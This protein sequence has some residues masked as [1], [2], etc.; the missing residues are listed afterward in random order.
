VSFPGKLRHVSRENRIWKP[1]LTSA[2]AGIRP[3]IGSDI[4]DVLFPSPSFS[5]RHSD[6]RPHPIRHSRRPTPPAEATPLPSILTDA[7]FVLPT[8]F[9]QAGPR[10]A[11]R[12]SRAVR[13]ATAAHAKPMRGHCPL[14]PVPRTKR[15]SMDNPATQKTAEAAVAALPGALRNMATTGGN[16]P[17]CASLPAK[18]RMHGIFSTACP[19]GRSIRAAAIPSPSWVSDSMWCSQCRCEVTADA[20]AQ[21]GAFDV[22]AVLCAACRSPLSASAT[23]TGGPLS[24]AATSNAECGMWNA[25]LSERHVGP[26]SEFRIPNSELDPP[27]DVCDFELA[28]DLRRA[29]RILRIDSAHQEHSPMALA[30]L[31]AGDAHSTAKGGRRSRGRQ[32]RRNHRGFAARLWGGLT[33][34]VVCTGGMGV[35]FGAALL[36]STQALADDSVSRRD[37]LWNW[38]VLTAL[39]GQFLL[40][41]GIA[42]RWSSRRVSSTRRGHAVRSKSAD[43]RPRQPSRALSPLV[44]PWSARSDA[45]LAIALDSAL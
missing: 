19:V 13:S 44:P 30:A 38:G 1:I 39:A 8:L 32:H 34:L 7:A 21:A 42:L 45:A 26:N 43:R 31:L 24:T 15:R 17:A 36:A 23:P 16:L 4:K 40:F 37:D 5:Q 33:W 35:T 20:S 14:L 25:E 27:P 3:R 9:R 11:Y 6:A 22:A 41:V 2:C 10:A 29:R 18:G 12:L 28:D